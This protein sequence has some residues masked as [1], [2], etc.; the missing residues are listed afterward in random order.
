MR[1]LMVI[2]LIALIALCGCA[3]FEKQAAADR[4]YYATLSDAEVIGRTMT[5]DPNCRKPSL[6]T[7]DACRNPANPRLEDP[8]YRDFCRGADNCAAEY[9]GAEN[10]REKAREELDRRAAASR[11]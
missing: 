7:L 4:A 5:P 10:T 3:H 9:R 6:D 11:Q 8:Y 2:A 1:T